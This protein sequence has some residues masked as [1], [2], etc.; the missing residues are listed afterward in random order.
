MSRIDE[1]GHRIRAELL[2]K[3]TDNS[4]NSAGFCIFEIFLFL[5]RLKC[6]LAKFSQIV[7]NFSEFSKNRRDR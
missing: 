6:V 2:A 4:A 5:T 1:T 7:P 3:P